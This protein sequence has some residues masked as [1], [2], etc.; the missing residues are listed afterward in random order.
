MASTSYHGGEVAFGGSV[1]VEVLNPHELVP[2]DTSCA[3]AEAW[4]CMEHL[5]GVRAGW[6]QAL[7]LC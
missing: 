4:R 2:V 3:R 1:G 5:C 6:V 7:G